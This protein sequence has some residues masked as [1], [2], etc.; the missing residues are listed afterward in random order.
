MIMSGSGYLL[1]NLL[2]GKGGS[3]GNLVIDSGLT[4]VYGA[5]GGN[6]GIVRGRLNYVNGDN[7]EFIQSAPVPSGGLGGG[8]GGSYYLKKNGTVV[9]FAGA[10]G[11]AGA[12]AGT[13]GAHGGSGGYGGSP[14]SAGG[15]G[16]LGGSGGSAGATVLQDIWDDIYYSGFLPATRTK[17]TPN[18]AVAVA[19]GGS[20]GNG[21]NCGGYGNGI[22]SSGCSGG[23]GGTNYVYYL[24][25]VTENSSN[26][27]AGA[28]SYSYTDFPQIS[29]INIAEASVGLTNIG[30]TSQLSVSALPAGYTSSI[31]YSSNNTAVATVS[32]SG[33]ITAV[34]EGTCTITA[35]SSNNA[36]INDTCAVTVTLPAK[37]SALFS[38]NF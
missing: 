15:V 37:G 21:I 5:A 1:I 9:A 6:G 27:N 30:Q 32:A 13:A 23:G 25:A 33:L 11:G 14:P 19:R 38:H 22:A 2:G 31:L 34:G 18:G 28:A 35:Y 4:T 12:P 16:A 26:S 20:G 17:G 24:D 36:G 8:S 10:G 3:S 7:I 29:S